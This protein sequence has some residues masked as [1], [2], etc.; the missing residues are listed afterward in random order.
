M[1]STIVKF[2]FVPPK[3]VASGMPLVFEIE[4]TTAHPGM[5]LQLSA[6]PRVTVLAA[7][8]PGLPSNPSRVALPLGQFRMAFP[9]VVSGPPGMTEIR[10][11]L[12]DSTGAPLL[13]TT[14]TDYIEI[15]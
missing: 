2:Q 4:G 5:A 9:V 10:G 15:L 13:A 6:P 12:L 14:M 11:T 7:V 1:P 8:P 3:E